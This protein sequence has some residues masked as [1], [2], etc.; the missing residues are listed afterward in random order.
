MEKMVEL[1]NSGDI[2]SNSDFN[3]IKSNNHPLQRMKNLRQI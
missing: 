1:F 3:I 2:K